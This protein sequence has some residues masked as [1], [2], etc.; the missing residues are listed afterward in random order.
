VIIREP[1]LV[2]GNGKHGNAKR[3][4][5]IHRAEKKRR[6]FKR[7]YSRYK[8]EW[9]IKLFTEATGYS[10]FDSWNINRLKEVRKQVEEEYNIPINY[11]S[12]FVYKTALAF[13]EWKNHTPKNCIGFFA[14]ERNMKEVSLWLSEQSFYWR[15]RRS[16]YPEDFGKRW[17]RKLSIVHQRLGIGKDTVFESE[18][19]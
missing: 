12:V 1:V 2:K 9:F 15:K 19:L 10:D 3:I 8:N 4:I 7:A 14:N 13:F 17:G 18:V 11:F 6:E 5:E 16:R